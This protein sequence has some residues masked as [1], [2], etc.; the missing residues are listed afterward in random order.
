MYDKLWSHLCV[1]TF[2]LEVTIFNPLT[3]ITDVPL[4]DKEAVQD[5]DLD[6]LPVLTNT[7]K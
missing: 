6:L 3:S 4:E 1:Y 2:W 7:F 5:K